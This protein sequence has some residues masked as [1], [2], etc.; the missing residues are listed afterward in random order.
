[1]ANLIT[2]EQLLESIDL[3]FEPRFV[4]KDKNGMI[5]IF[6]HR[7]KKAGYYW[8]DENLLYSKVH[9]SFIKLA[10][11]DGKDWT[12]C[13]YEMP[14]KTKGEIEKIKVY[15]TLSDYKFKPTEKFEPMCFME[16]IKKINE[17]VDA[18]NELKKL[19]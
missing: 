6:E 15:G 17:L 13:I 9:V 7:P 11:F 8:L 3:D 4:T 12:E 1:M 19:S 14:R 10:E 5:K 16:L 18:V 2:I